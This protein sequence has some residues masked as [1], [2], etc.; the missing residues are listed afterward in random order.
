MPVRR[1]R[2]TWWR[3]TGVPL[4]THLVLMAGCVVMLFP[5][6]WMLGTSFKP[7]DET[8]LWPPRVLPIHWT[9]TNYPKVMEAAPFIRY[10]FN[11]V[12]VSCP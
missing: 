12:L 4:A 10:F 7:A 11:S 8:M 1:A 6:L 3:R 5:Y 9:W 2:E